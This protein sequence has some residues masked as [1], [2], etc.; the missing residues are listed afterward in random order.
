MKLLAFGSSG[1]H[2][3]LKLTF[4]TGRE[5]SFYVTVLATNLPMKFEL[6]EIG[7]GITIVHRYSN[8]FLAGSE[9]DVSCL[10]PNRAENMARE[11]PFWFGASP[12]VDQPPK[13][14]MPGVAGMF[15]F[16]EIK[17]LIQCRPNRAT[18]HAVRMIDITPTAW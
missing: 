10:E 18:N 6:A 15:G 17:G 12:R 8:R 9:L 11:P 2:W 14:M 3:Y 13:A 16:G 1:W 4:G 5:A 7:E